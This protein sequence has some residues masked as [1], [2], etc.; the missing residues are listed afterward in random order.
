[1]I[2]FGEI[3]AQS[4]LASS[5]RSTFR[6]LI[7]EDC[8]LPIVS[9][10]SPRSPLH[11]QI[12]EHFIGI[13]T[14]SFGGTLLGILVGFPIRFHN[15]SSLAGDVLSLAG[16]WWC[17]RCKVYRESR[18]LFCVD[19]SQPRLSEWLTRATTALHWDSR[20]KASHYREGTRSGSVGPEILR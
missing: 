10:K 3:S 14:L 20:P 7:S 13:P 15:F 4:K 17:R 19:I 5:W 16:W 1:M 12:S 6:A 8:H 2:S 18:S 11:S 9:N